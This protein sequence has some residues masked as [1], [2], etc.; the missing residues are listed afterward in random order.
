MQVLCSVWWVVLEVLPIFYVLLGMLQDGQFVS[1]SM[2]QVIILDIKH[3]L[4]TTTSK[5]V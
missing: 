1:N 3:M 5:G 2:E 4:I